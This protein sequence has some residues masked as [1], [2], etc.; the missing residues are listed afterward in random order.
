MEFKN[1]IL[2]IATYLT[3]SVMILGCDGKEK[4]VDPYVQLSP[5]IKY[6][7][8][9]NEYYVETTNDGT[10]KFPEFDCGKTGKVPDPIS[11]CEGLSI[12]LC[13]EKTPKFRNY[14]NPDVFS[15]HMFK[16]TLGFVTPKCPDAIRER[17]LEVKERCINKLESYL[18]GRE[19][20]GF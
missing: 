16:T 5:G 8:E 4:S 17:D 19:M 7:I 1:L 20:K 10:C 12:R 6:S 2:N 14:R 9:T 18:M 11:R 3:I 13:D 15:D